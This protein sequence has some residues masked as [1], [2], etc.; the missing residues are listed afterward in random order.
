LVITP[1]LDITD[2]ITKYSLQHRIKYVRLTKKTQFGKTV[3]YAQLVCEGNPYVKNK[4]KSTV[5]GNVGLDIGPSTIAAVGEKGALIQ[6]FCPELDP[7]QKEIIK[8]QRQLDRQR[9]ANNPD[10]FNPNGT[11]KKGVKWKYSEAMKSTKG[12][13]AEIS[14][15]LA[16]YRKNSHNK[17]AHTVS[18]LGDKFLVEKNSY[19]GWQKSHWGK[20][21][22]HRAPSMFVTRL[23]KIS[24]VED[25]STYETKLSQTCLCGVVK[26]KSL[27]DRKHICGCGIE[28]QRDLF[29][30][31]LARYVKDNKLNVDEAKKAYQGSCNILQAAL[32]ETENSQKNGVFT[33]TSI[34]GKPRRV[35]PENI[36]TNNSKAVDVVASRVKP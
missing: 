10:N 4:H 8:L 25:V 30:A 20:S 19:S 22:G 27:S 6:A 23:K 13:L 28:M 31:Y 16:A 14:R 18:K 2:E 1:V 29:S 3:Y 21:V 11:C 15:K 32:S 7:K 35:L 34:F 17:L 36:F 33:P 24:N 9:R 5:I 12:K 26:K